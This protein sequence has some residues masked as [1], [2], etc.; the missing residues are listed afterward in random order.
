METFIVNREKL[1][2]VMKKKGMNYSDLGRLL[3][4]DRT[5]ISRKLRGVR[6]F[7]ESEITQLVKIFG[8]AVLFL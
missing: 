3:L 8:K 6:S 1:K 2:E 4:I 5:S 7:N